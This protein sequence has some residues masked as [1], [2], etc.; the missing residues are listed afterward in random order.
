MGGNN[1]PSMFISTA[2][3]KIFKNR[4]HT[5]KVDDGQRLF[6]AFGI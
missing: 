6:Y 5:C 2:E 3:L 4:L 1:P